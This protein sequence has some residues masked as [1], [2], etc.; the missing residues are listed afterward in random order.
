MN[1]NP[2]KAQLAVEL[3]TTR[4]KLYQLTVANERLTKKRRAICSATDIVSFMIGIVVGMAIIAVY[5]KG[6]EL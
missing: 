1:G 2:T 6:T 3:A 4:M 5:L